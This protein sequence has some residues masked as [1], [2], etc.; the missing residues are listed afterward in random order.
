MLHLNDSPLPTPVP[1]MFTTPWD[2]DDTN[3]LNTALFMGNDCDG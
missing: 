2:T 1:D 3:S